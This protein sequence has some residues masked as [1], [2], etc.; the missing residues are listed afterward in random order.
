M[1]RRQVA[2]TY[3]GVAMKKQMKKLTLA[4]ETVRSL[5]GEELPVVVGG[6]DPNQY[7]YYCPSYRVVCKYPPTW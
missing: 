5:A 7:T 4:K 1:P 6:Y 3:K 2:P